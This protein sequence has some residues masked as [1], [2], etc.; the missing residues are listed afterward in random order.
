M[1]CKSKCWLP[2]TTESN[3]GQI[4]GALFFVLGFLKLGGAA[5]LV[6][7]WQGCEPR[8]TDFDL[9]ICRGI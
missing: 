8:G 7:H 6:E 1:I 2:I 4:V 9:R 3:N 5:A